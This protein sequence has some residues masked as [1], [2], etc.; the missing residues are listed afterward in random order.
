MSPAQE[1]LGR[2]DL[3]LEALSLGDT[4]PQLSNVQA[5]R[6]GEQSTTLFDA[7]VNWDSKTVQLM[8]SYGGPLTD[9]RIVSITM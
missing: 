7:Q 5:L 1:S 3:T 8:V 4:A 2:F 6:H 9:E